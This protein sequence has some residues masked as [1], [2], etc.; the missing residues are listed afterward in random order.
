MVH[1]KRGML[2]IIENILQSTKKGYELKTHIAYEAK[3]DSRTIKKYIPMLVKMGLVKQTE[4]R[5]YKITK[6]GLGFL[7]NYAQ[8]KKYNSKAT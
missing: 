2:N 1:S 7:K 4:K 8:M 6:R 3:I 5:K